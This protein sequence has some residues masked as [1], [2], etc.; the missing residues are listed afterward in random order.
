MMDS[1][2]SLGGSCL[3][4]GDAL[5]SGRYGLSEE[6]MTALFAC[7]SSE[8]FPPILL[9]DSLVVVVA[10]ISNVADSRMRRPLA[11]EPA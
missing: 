11:S 1:H 4:L 10:F 9:A 5:V 7:G 2:K 8:D 3:V 6:L